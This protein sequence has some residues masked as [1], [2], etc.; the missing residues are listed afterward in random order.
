V[1]QAQRGPPLGIGITPCRTVGRAA[2]GP[3]YFALG[4]SFRIEDAVEI[5]VDQV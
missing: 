3:P 5:L 2:L 4:E 1:G